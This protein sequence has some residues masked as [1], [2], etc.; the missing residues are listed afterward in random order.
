[1]EAKKLKTF[2]DLQAAWQEDE[3]VELINGDIVKRPMSRFEH[4]SSQGMVFAELTPYRKG[5]GPGGWWFGTEISVR[6]SE[7]HCPRHDVA[8]WRK[9]RVHEKPKGV[10]AVIPDW[11]CEI[12]SPGHEKKD[13]LHNLLLLQEKQVPFYWIISPE[14][15]SLIACKLVDG[16]YSVI[17]AIDHGEGT[18]RIEPFLEVEFDLNELF[19][20]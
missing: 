6:Y 20:A 14:D 9:A 10:V 8:G 18:A 15:Q 19:H 4:G 7:H 13:F 11:V 16:K 3:R 1:M 2:E 17:E 5:K 12:T